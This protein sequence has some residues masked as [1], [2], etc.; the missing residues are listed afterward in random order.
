MVI[1]SHPPLSTPLLSQKDIPS[2]NCSGPRSG[3]YENR[4]DGLPLQM[5]GSRPSTTPSSSC[6]P[7][8]CPRRGH[9]QC[10]QNI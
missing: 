7:L 4:R 1:L 5:S 10:R 9:S 2:P 3:R 6:V 8:L